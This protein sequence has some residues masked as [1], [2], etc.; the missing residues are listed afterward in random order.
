M[1]LGNRNV[2]PKREV[3]LR[4]AKSSQNM[5]ESKWD[6]GKQKADPQGNVCVCVSCAHAI[7]LACRFPH[8][9]QNEPDGVG[10]PW[11]T[12][13]VPHLPITELC[14]SSFG[15]HTAGH[16]YVETGGWEQAAAD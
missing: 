12:F 5:G 14:F 6:R 1:G 15:S 2:F 9:L 8:F 10:G 7:S 4:V 16:F 13:Q 3:G 11:S